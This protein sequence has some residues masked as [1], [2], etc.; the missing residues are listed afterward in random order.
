M[1]RFVIVNAD[2]FGLSAGVNRGVLRA[3]RD[4]ILT[5]ASLMVRAE[6]AKDASRR[7][8]ELDLGLHI[9]LGEWVY[10]D[11]DWI[12]RYERVSP[13]DADAVEREIRQQ[14]ALFVELTGKLPTHLDSHQHV[15]CHEPVRTIATKMAQVLDVPLRGIGAKIHYCGSFYG[16]SGK[17]VSWPEAISVDSLIDLL[18]TLPPGITELACHPGN[19]S[20][21]DSS[22]RV[23][24]SL[25]VDALCDP[26]VRDVIEE[27]A[28]GLITFDD[29][30]FRDARRAE[31]N[32]VAAVFNSGIA[33]SR[34]S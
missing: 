18:R 1:D 11:G 23:E 20:Q 15:H 29:L 34:Q 12:T 17:G 27:Q 10:R 2:D 14:L 22:Y 30:R 31:P 3:R 32:G 4:G 19:D 7:A 21:L 6:A 25:E 5:S 24:R 16:Q 8:H 26:R 13:E 9:D 33:E 28:I